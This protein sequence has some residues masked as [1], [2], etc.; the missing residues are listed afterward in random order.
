MTVHIKKMPVPG[1][2][3]S[4]DRMGIFQENIV[5]KKGSKKQG[6][7]S[8]LVNFNSFFINILS[9]QSEAHSRQPAWPR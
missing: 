4:R 5:S 8:F 9:R 2:A 6:N 7:S 1:A 3:T